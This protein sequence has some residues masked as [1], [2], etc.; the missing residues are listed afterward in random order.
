[1][2][3]EAIALRPKLLAR[4]RQITFSM[5]DAEDLVQGAYLAF[6]KK[7][8]EPRTP[9]KLHNWLRIVMANLNAH[10]FREFH[11]AVVASYEAIE[12]ERAARASK[13]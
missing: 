5:A 11:G 13:E 3:A 10:R 1:M 6:A 4:A 7:P 9:A 8:P 2:T 12:E